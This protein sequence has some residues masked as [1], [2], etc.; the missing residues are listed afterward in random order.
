MNK[1]LFATTATAA[2]LLGG[3]AS[4]QGISLFGSARLGLTYQEGR[5]DNPARE[6]VEATSRVRFG[7]NMTGESN[8]GVTFGASVQAHE[9]EAANNGGL[10]GTVF[11]SGSMGTLTYGDTSGADENWVGD[12]PGNV[13]L[14]GIGDEN[15]TP[16]I[17]NGGG[18]AATQEGSDG[19]R[20]LSNPLARPT[21]R[22]DF[23]LAGF[24]I[25]ASTNR[26]LQDV[27]LG[28]GWSGQAFGDTGFSVGLGWNKFSDFYTV[29]NPIAGAEPVAGGDQFSASLGAD[30]GDISTGIVYQKLDNDDGKYS[31][32]HIGASMPFGA[33]T[34]GAFYVKAI[35]ANV[36]GEDVDRD[37]KSSYGLTAEYD[38]GG[39]ASIAGGIADTF[40][41]G[42]QSDFGVRMSF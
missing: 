23:D 14:T 8:S 32:F 34:L 22:Y 4:A 25:S 42:T 40:A 18:A 24:G 2:L 21:V 26:T 29:E 16:F 12:V 41:A 35:D 1:V 19:L 20:F 30:F 6:E 37:G 33:T 31:T 27:A 5:D 11:I 39:G 13:S 17:S 3:M 15:E 10:D 36:D 9:A 28:L 38:L 7:V